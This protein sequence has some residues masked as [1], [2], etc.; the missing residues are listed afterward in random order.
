LRLGVLFAALLFCALG[1]AQTY[2]SK[3]IR[4]VVPLAAG[5][6]GDT[7]GRLVAES[8]GTALNA[9]VV[10]DNRPGAGG[11]IG[12]EVVARSAADGYTLLVTSSSHVLNSALRPGKLSYDPLKDF[13]AI[14]QIADTHQVLLAHPSL[15]IGTVREMIAAAK[16]APGKLTYGSAGNGSATHLNAELLK[17]LAGIDLVHVPYK[18]STQ[19][20][21][22][23]LSGQVNLAIDGLLPTL[24][25][26]RSGKLRALAVTNG[27]RAAVAPEIPTMA[28]AGVP[29]YRSDT[30]YALLAPAG[31]PEIIVA[32]LREAAVSSLASPAMRDRL[33]QQGAE[34][35]GGTSRQLQ[36]LMQEDLARW[37]KVV[38][39]TGAHVE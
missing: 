34:P 20:R 4:V 14:T 28:E 1:N 16:A 25:L 10:V 5:G 35:V 38:A 18:G 3:P 32:R 19:A 8:L 29:G 21:T 24:P 12:T 23:L 37:R 9:P 31:V 27:K 36:E 11:V 6:T 15:G 26:V 22:D 17:S 39:D 33:L 2:P 7:L 13:I 30:W